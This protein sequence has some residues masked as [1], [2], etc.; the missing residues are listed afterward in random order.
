MR[1]S[2]ILILLLMLLAVTKLSLVNSRVLT[3]PI[4][5]EKLFTHEHVQ[6][7]LKFSTKSNMVLSENQYHTMVSGPSRRGSGH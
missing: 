2:F 1:L 6:E 4:K 3:S 5:T 7:G